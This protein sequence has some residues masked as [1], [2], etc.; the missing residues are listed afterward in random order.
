MTFFFLFWS[1]IKV[2]RGPPILN[3][4]RA[5]GMLRLALAVLYWNLLPSVSKRVKL[6]ILAC[7]S[8]STDHRLQ[9]AS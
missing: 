9:L 8:A 6:N 3:L 1:S 5:S 2:G 4:P 7:V